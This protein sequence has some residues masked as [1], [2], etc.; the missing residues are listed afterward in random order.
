MGKLKRGPGGQDDEAGD[1]IWTCLDRISEKGRRI[2]IQWI[3]SHCGI[4]GNE[5]ADRLAD[6]GSRLDQSD[7]GLPLRVAKSNLRRTRRRTR[8][9]PANQLGTRGRPPEH[10]CREGE[11]A[12]AQLKTGHSYLLKAYRHRLG[13]ETDPICIECEDQVPETAEHLLCTCP[14]WTA[15]RTRAFGGPVIDLRDAIDSPGLAKFLRGTG[16]R[17]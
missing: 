14:R 13:K 9:L 17:L 6:Q 15:L 10:L 1:N 7:V 2:S 5:M 16:R 4:E 8:G 12:A 3:P 11:V